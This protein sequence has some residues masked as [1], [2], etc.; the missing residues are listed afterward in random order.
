MIGNDLV[1]LRVAKQDSNW[2][3]NG[4]LDKIFT[5]AEQNL[6]LQ[7]NPRDEMVWLLWSMKESAYKIHNRQ[8]GERKFAPTQL[9]CAAIKQ[10]QNQWHG[11]IT[12]EGKQYYTDS[13]ITP[14]YI[15]TIAAIHQAQLPQVRT[16]IYQI[17]DIPLD[18]RSTAPKCIS[19]HGA[20]LALVYC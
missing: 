2:R 3:R 9:V 7:S 16:L 18:Y 13:Q 6:I 12:T 10:S 4:Y 20:Y 11:Q 5:V 1:D 8:T 14:D 17:P 19:H 15:H